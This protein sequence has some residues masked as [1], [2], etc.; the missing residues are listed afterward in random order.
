MSVIT[1]IDSNE[2]DRRSVHFVVLTTV[3]VC[4]MRKLRF[5]NSSSE[6][7]QIMIPEPEI[8]SLADRGEIEGLPTWQGIRMM[9]LKAGNLR[10]LVPVQPDSSVVRR[11]KRDGNM[12]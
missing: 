7:D 2:M 12:L 11:E 10:I 5:I 6:R 9:N 8:M 4:P 1:V 3:Q